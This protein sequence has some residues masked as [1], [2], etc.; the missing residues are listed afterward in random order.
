[1]KKFLIIFLL[2]TSV[3]FA[4]FNLGFRDNRY[5]LIGYTNSLLKISLEQ[6]IYC[7]KPGFQKTRLY[8]GVERNLD[9]FGFE[10]L[11]YYGSLWNRDY[12]DYGVFVKGNFRIKPVLNV[13]AALNLNYDSYYEGDIGSLLGV[14]VHLWKSISLFG[15]YS[16][17][18]E[19]RRFEDRIKLGLIIKENKLQVSPAISLPIE[20]EIKTF[21]LMCDFEY[22]F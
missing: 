4:E 19:Y 14:D 9:L 22:L 5:G 2:F 3:T 15:Q 6:S 20:D 11:P 8:V 13:R 1:M 17:I 10:I 12:Y 16:S 7:E 18:P 21:R